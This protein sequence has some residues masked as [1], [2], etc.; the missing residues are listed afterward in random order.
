MIVSFLY[1]NLTHEQ[2]RQHS[3]YMRLQHSAKEPEDVAYY[4][5]KAVALELIAINNYLNIFT[6]PEMVTTDIENVI[7]RVTKEEYTEYSQDAANLLIRVREAV[8]KYRKEKEEAGEEPATSLPILE[9]LEDAAADTFQSWVN[10]IFDK[11]INC[12]LVA[13]MN[14]SGT[15]AGEVDFL[16]GVADEYRHRIL[17]CI[18]KK[19]IEMYPKRKKELKAFKESLKKTHSTDDKASLKLPAMKSTAVDKLGFPID[20]IN[21]ISTGIW[22]AISTEESGQLAFAF[23]TTNKK[24]KNGKEATVLCAINWDIQDISIT[25][26]LTEWDKRVYIAVGSLFNGGNEAM[27]IN[28]I[29]TLMGNTGDPNA[30]QI[31]RINESLTKMAAARLYIDNVKERDA[32][33]KYPLFKYDA[34]LLPFERLEVTHRGK[35]ATAVKLLREP[36]LISFARDRK[37]CTTIELK[38]LQSPVSKTDN[39]LRIDDYLLERIA[40]MKKNPALSR[41][42][43]FK[44][45]CE[46]CRITDKKQ[47]QR[48]PETINRYLEHYQ[49]TGYITGYNVDNSKDINIEL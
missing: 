41:K 10:Y 27:T 2:D 22:G 19:Y 3:E 40:H 15:E 34:P 25:K 37:Q 28:Q 24:K 17:D 12:Q 16:E 30:R 33:Y 38:T 42:I 32:G 1:E 31:K 49:A 20:K 5:E 39:N 45:I 6:T 9:T 11:V 18:E 36:P 43:L 8:E 4:R 44:S 13:L 35:T 26:Q 46:A 29:Y 21:A 14:I 23:D 48:A 7:N 47:R